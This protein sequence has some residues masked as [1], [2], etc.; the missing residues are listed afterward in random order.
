[1]CCGQADMIRQRAR[2]RITQGEIIEAP[3][4]SS[5]ATPPVPVR[6]RVRHSLGVVGGDRE[7]GRELWAGIPTPG[8][9]SRYRPGAGARRRGGSESP[10]PTGDRER[11]Q[12]A[13]SVASEPAYSRL[14]SELL[15][16]GGPAARPRVSS[17]ETAGG[18]SGVDPGMSGTPGR[19]KTM[20]ELVHALRAAR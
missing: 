10:E 6:P 3:R 12:A 14:R 19:T 20:S 4:R 13:A 17:D 5:S 8:T 9:S 7:R 1:M 16:R 15:G 18:V 11:H 2:R